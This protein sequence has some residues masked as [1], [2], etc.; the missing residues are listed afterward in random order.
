MRG[1]SIAILVVACTGETVQTPTTDAGGGDVGSTACSPVAGNLLKNPSF[2]DWDGAV[3]RNWPHEHPTPPRKK[4]GG[5]AD[6]S[7]WIEIDYE[8]YNPIY[9]TVVFE[10]PLPIGT[11]VEAGAALKHVAG[12]YGPINI[13]IRIDGG[14]SKEPSHTPLDDWTNFKSTRTLDKPA[15]SITLQFIGD[16]CQKQT[17]GIDRAWLIIK[18]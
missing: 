10:T 16:D 12:N 15:S 3:V 17:F 18:K 5:A 6:C 9:Q 1:A 14:E 11:V 8:C 13:D 4:T 7:T 2:E